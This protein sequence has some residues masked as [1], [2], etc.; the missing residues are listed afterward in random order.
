VDEIGRRRSRLSFMVIVP[1]TPLSLIADLVDVVDA[2]RLLHRVAQPADLGWPPH[3]TG[4][5]GL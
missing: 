1:S 5:D 2:A 3:R 4:T